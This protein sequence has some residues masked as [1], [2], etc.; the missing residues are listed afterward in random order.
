MPV[1]SRVRRRSAA[2]LA[3]TALCLAPALA[4]ASAAPTPHDELPR[5]VGLS[6]TD[7]LGLLAAGETSSVDLVQAYLDRIAAYDDAYADQPGLQAV[8]TVSPT[9][10]ENARLLDAERAAGISRGP[11]HGVPVLVK[12]NYATYDMPTSAGSEA[13]ADYQTTED[14]TAVERLRDAGAIIVGKTNMAEFAWHGT[15]TLSSVRGE[16]HNPYDQDVSASGSS[17]GTGAAIAAGFAAAGLGTDSCGS[18][19]GPSAHQS[20]VG[21]RPT[22]GLTSV[23]GIVPLSVRQ[24]VSGPMTT[25]VEDAALLG[26]V[27]AGVD[28]ADPQTAIAAEQ[29][30]ATF[31]PGLSDTALQGK[32]IGTFHWDYS[33]ATP[34]GP[35]PGTEEVT[36]I[37]DRAVDDLAAQGAEIVDVPFTRE[38]VQQQLASGGWI[39]MRPSVDAFFAATEA[40]WPA[41]LAEL[42]APTDRLTFSDVVADG[43]SS[44][45]QAT[46]DSWL[47][48]A[49]VPN[50]D[51]DAAVAAQEAGKVAMDAFFVEHDLDA[52]A[53]PTSEA[54]ANPDWAGTTFCD[55][56]ANTGIPTIS[57]P[58]GFT[59]A[60][61]P[62]GL[63]LAAPRSTDA[64]LLAMA[65]DYEQATEHR[66]PPAS[67]PELP[68]N[69]VIPK[70]VIAT[71]PSRED[72]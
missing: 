19:I 23:A 38:F 21:Y 24:D 59:A 72:G 15:Y 63:E 49:D 7:Q 70:A 46:I 51:Y 28:P 69:G 66:L 26:S 47:A 41:G 57:L 68:R 22:M 32:R 37:V 56:G 29:D 44:L 43:K 20:L 39:D 30:P 61:L 54:P 6:V 60:G 58:A 31:V 2:L 4:P 18:I 50:P 64:T 52:L 27:L 14:S 67:T 25:T 40:Q 3:A 1:P 13:L 62:V 8:V 53:M 17:G 48:L 5:V 10:L 34:E 33:T 36:A 71:G 42:T 16:T 35:R 12:D 11:L 65:Y 55:V 9:A 45:D